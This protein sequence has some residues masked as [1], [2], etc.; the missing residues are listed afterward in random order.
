MRSFVAM[1][2]FVIAGVKQVY[3]AGALL[4]FQPACNGH[5]AALPG[6]CSVS[7]SEVQVGVIRFYISAVEL[8]SKGKRVWQEQ[9]SYHLIDFSDPATM[10]HRLEV[11][12]GTHFDKIRFNLGID[13]VT[14]VSGAMGGD[15]DPAKGMYW[16]WQSGYINFKMEGNFL[17]SSGSKQAFQFHLGGYAFPFASLQ[18]IELAVPAGGSVKVGFDA[19]RFM[20]GVNINEV[21]NIMSPGANAVKLSAAASGAFFVLP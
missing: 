4:S 16:A 8:Y 10:Q 12:E 14:N 19:A 21:H 17:S 15:L 11:P 18:T 7:G 5:F 1:L 6:A 20:E 13:S 3:A 2:V 9:S